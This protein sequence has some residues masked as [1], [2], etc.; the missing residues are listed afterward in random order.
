MMQFMI[1]FQ[2]LKSYLKMNEVHHDTFST[3]Y[4]FIDNSSNKK[5][6]AT[7]S[8][9][10]FE[11]SKKDEFLNE[12]DKLLKIDHPAI[13]KFFG[14]SL[15]KSKHQTKPMIKNEYIPFKRFYDVLKNVHKESEWNL[16]KK[17]I[18]IYGIASALLYLNFRKI[19]HPTPNPKNI[20][21]DSNYQPKLTEIGFFTQPKNSHP[22]SKLTSIHFDESIFY[23]PPELLTDRN[24]VNEKSDVYSFGIISY[25]ILSNSFLFRKN[26][27][28]QSELCSKITKGD[29]RPSFDKEIDTN[30]KDLIDQCLSINQDDRPSLSDIVSRL[31]NDPN[32]ITDEV[33][34]E[35]FD[36]YK[37]ILIKYKKSI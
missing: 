4:S 35:E 21:I 17:L 26:K 25:E 3:T 27:Y 34:K 23:L 13:Q 5:Y 14:F 20:L 31:E 8:N 11:L 18:N 1:L 19:M 24:K 6:Y 32:F 37:E 28:N 7:L 10:G 12:V 33:N 9:F 30:F 22:A 29:L 36:N 16:T 15:I 2:M